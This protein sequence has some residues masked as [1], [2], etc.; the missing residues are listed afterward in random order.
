MC[1]LNVNTDS[2]GFRDIKNFKENFQ[3]KKLLGCTRGQSDPENLLLISK[4]KQRHLSDDCL[5]KELL[6]ENM[7][8]QLELEINK[9]YICDMNFS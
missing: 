9:K 7:I 6:L 1:N 2:R 5:V 8:H 4:R 3:D